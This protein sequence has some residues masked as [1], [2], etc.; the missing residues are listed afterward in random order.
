[1][2]TYQLEQTDSHRV[3]LVII[4]NTAISLSINVGT[5]YH[6]DIPNNFMIKKTIFLIL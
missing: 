6:H 2:V 4:K 3:E 1:M 5:G